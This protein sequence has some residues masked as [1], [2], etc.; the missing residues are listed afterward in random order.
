LRLH[1]LKQRQLAF[2]SSVGARNWTKNQDSSCLQ[3]H[4]KHTHI[5]TVMLQGVTI[6]Q[7]W[8]ADGK[9][10]GAPSWSV[11]S[12]PELS[13]G[14][15]Q[16]HPWLH[17]QSMSR[18][19]VLPRGHSRAP[20]IT[21]A[22]SGVGLSRPCIECTSCSASGW[23]QW[24]SM[25]RRKSISSDRP[26]RA[27]Q[28]LPLARME[29]SC[30]GQKCLRVRALSFSELQAARVS[31]EW[32]PGDFKRMR[33]TKCG[34]AEGMVNSASGN[35]SLRGGTCTKPSTSCYTAW[36]RVQRKGLYAGFREIQH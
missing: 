29:P 33:A 35:P 12:Q 8:R 14:P 10:D 7:V 24:G 11:S 19:C 13:R 15:P 2:A 31:V 9:V 5:A 27:Q 1:Y 32:D 30:E 21:E 3:K 6:G 18:G 22:T 25:Y 26:W 36:I 23:G 34:R 16:Y 28:T 20:S 4:S 17:P